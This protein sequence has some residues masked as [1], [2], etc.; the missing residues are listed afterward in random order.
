[1]NAPRFLRNPQLVLAA[2]SDSV[3]VVFVFRYNT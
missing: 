3:V 1:M 2:A